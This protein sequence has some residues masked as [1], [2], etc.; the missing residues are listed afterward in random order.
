MEEKIR[1]TENIPEDAERIEANAEEAESIAEATDAEATESITEVTESIVKATDAEASPENTASEAAESIAEP[2]ASPENTS[3]EAAESIAEACESIVK[4]TEA[5][6][7]NM[8][9]E[10]G[11]SIAEACE[12]AK[13]SM[14]WHGFQKKFLLWLIAA[15]YFARAFLIFSGN[16]YL[17]AE[18]RAAIYAGIPL[19]RILDYAFA[20]HCVLGG[21]FAI[22]SAVC[23]KTRILIG[24]NIALCAGEAA[25]LLL[26]WL[27]TELPPINPQGIALMLAHGLLLWA[28]LRYYRNRK[29]RA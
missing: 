15:A 27:L 17:S 25:Y 10:A 5:S 4:A 3:S 8:P 7:E 23:R 11:E 1:D 29:D 18:I 6:P 28:N 9:S 19:L 13:P 26:R 2:E 24:N 16:I 20:A 22:L 14:V 12:S 21:V